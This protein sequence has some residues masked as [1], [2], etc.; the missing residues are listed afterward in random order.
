[1]VERGLDP[2]RALEASLDAHVAAHDDREKQ[3]AGVGPVAEV[4]KG[5]L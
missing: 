2:E 4:M 3:T 5:R 1:L